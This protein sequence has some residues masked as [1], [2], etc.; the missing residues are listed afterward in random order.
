MFKSD[1]KLFLS[2][3]N[4][5]NSAKTI[6]NECI[7]LLSEVELPGDSD[8]NSCKS[9]LENSGINV[10]VNKVEDTKESLM[11]LDQGF[12][13]E[14]MTLLQEF[15]Q[16]STIDTSNMSDEEKMQ[17][18]VQMS[19]Y[20]RDYNQTLLYMLEKYEESGM[21]TPELEEQL[22]MQK[23]IVEQYDVQDKMASLPTTSDEYI[24][25]FK[26][27]AEYDKKIINLNPNLTEEEKTSYLKQYEDSFNSNIEVLELNRNISLKNDELEKLANDDKYGTE[28]YYSK[29]NEIYQ[30]QIDFYNNKGVLTDAEKANLA[31]LKKYKELTNL[32]IDR[33][34]L[35]SNWIP[36]DGNS[37]NDEIFQLELDLNIGTEEEQAEKKRYLEMNGWEKALQN[38]GTFVT[39]VFEGIYNVE[40]QIFD[41]GVMICGEVGSW[42]GADT[43]WAEDLVEIDLSGDAYRGAIQDFGI[44]EHI[45]YGT[46]HEAGNF[47]G[48]MLAT[49]ALQFLPGGTVVMT[50]AHGLKGMGK[51][52]ETALK[53]GKDWDTA[54]NY[55]LATGTIEAGAAYLLYG[56][57]PKANKV[58]DNVGN[59]M[60][61]GINAIPGVSKITSVVSNGFNKVA[62]QGM[63]DYASNYLKS[64]LLTKFA[65]SGLKEHAKAKSGEI[66]GEKYN[67]AEANKEAWKSMTTTAFNEFVVNPAVNAAGNKIQKTTSVY[68]KADLRKQQLEESVKLDEKKLS[69]MKT[70]YESERSF[71][72]EADDLLESVTKSGRDASSVSSILEMNNLVNKIVEQKGA[73]SAAYD[74][75]LVWSEFAGKSFTEKFA[76]KVGS[77]IMKTVYDNVGI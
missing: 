43:K 27:N 15:L 73:I 7:R 45:A 11:K 38:T 42:F 14:Y 13:S 37:L 1:A 77:E 22:K 5:I 35:G 64:S 8:Y 74:G 32:Y 50:T 63:K 56:K 54:F 68:K 66:I 28:E 55:G 34:G 30:L 39:S 72:E 47:T 53:S 62:T 51:A 6:I 59:W 48:E 12:A 69:E 33:E 70:K 41:G 67:F 9:N 2:A 21:L 60:T 25:L 76:K 18:S 20:A 65:V 36:F 17:Y 52:G 26:Q 4:N 16:T 40:E 19:G 58:V 29:Q 10:L 23:A 24:K 61:K 44:N 75:A 57:T 71:R 3:N 46:A 49:I 31:N